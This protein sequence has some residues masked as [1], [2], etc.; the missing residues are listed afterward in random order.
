MSG[1]LVAAVLIPV[2]FGAVAFILLQRSR[3]P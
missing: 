3:K 1:G 2:M